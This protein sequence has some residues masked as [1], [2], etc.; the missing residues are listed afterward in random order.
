MGEGGGGGGSGGGTM[1]SFYC[2]THV[3]TQ[4]LKAMSRTCIYFIKGHWSWKG[5]HW[6]K[7]MG[8]YPLQ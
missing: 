3:V 7:C 4:S 6:V 1:V 5:A 8:G 2:Y